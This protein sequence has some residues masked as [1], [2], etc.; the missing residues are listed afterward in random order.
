M[1]VPGFVHSLKQGKIAGFFRLLL[2]FVAVIALALAY[3]LIQFRGLSSPAGIDQAQIAHEVAR[4]NGFS[5]KISAPWKRIFS[6][7]HL[8]RYLLGMFQTFTT[9]R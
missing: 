3:L 5:T 2:F 8:D 6:S 7:R 4:G 9:R 1:N